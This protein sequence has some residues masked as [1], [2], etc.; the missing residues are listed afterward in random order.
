MSNS[1]TPWLGNRVPNGYWQDPNNRVKYLVWLEEKLGY[2]SPEDWYQTTR[3][4]FE[5]N[6]GGGLLVHGYSSHLLRAP[7]E[8]YP[9][10]DW[11]PW[12]CKVTPRTFFAKI[13]NRRR[14]LDWI[15]E[16]NEFEN[17][18]DWYTKQKYFVLSYSGGAMIENYYNGSISRMLADI[19]R[20]YDWDLRAFIQSPNGYWKDDANALQ[21][22]DELA[23]KLGFTELDDWYQLSNRELAMH[24]G[25][26]SLY[27]RFNGSILQMMRHFY[28]EHDWFEF[29]F[30]MAPKGYWDLHEN[31]VEYMDWLG[32]KLGFKEMD[33]WYEV[34]V[35]DFNRNH[36]AAPLKMTGTSPSKIVIIAYPDYDWKEERFFDGKKNQKRLFR[37]V[38]EIYPEEEIKFDFK[39]HGMRFKSSN[40]PM[41]L[42]IWLP[43]LN[44]AFEYQGE[45]H[46]DDPK[47]MKRDEEKRNACE[48]AGIRLVEVPCTWNASKEYV[49]NLLS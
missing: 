24:G 32:S 14:F 3:K 49:V 20:D 13:E 15:A 11:K 18:S 38:K 41:E 10:Y 40:Y 26:G 8:L 16:E 6:K 37:I 19:Y 7:M 42:D 35:E 27:R 12:L 28:P 5:Q 29:R 30:S 31:L 45:Q 44:L 33:D 25:G 48:V 36:G 22:L 2:T 34:T 21:F 9:E 23:E 17:L 4:D 47:V 39:H 46:Y 43:N 1:E